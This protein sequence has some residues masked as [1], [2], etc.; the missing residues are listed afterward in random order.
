MVSA[1][2]VKHGKHEF[3]F[4]VN[5]PCNTPELREHLLIKYMSEDICRMHKVANRYC[6]TVNNDVGSTLS[7]IASLKKQLG[8]I[9]PLDIIQVSIGSY[10]CK[11][12]GKKETR[13]YYKKYEPSLIAGNQ[14][15]LSS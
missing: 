2:C 3:E 1:G 13:K 8:S 4:A 7:D 9:K 11:R 15:D 12:C 6:K 10:Y 14:Y 5:S